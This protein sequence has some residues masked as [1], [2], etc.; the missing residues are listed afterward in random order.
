MDHQLQRILAQLDQTNVNRR[1]ILK[2]ALAAGAI[3]LSTFLAACGDD[4]DADAGDGGQAAEGGDATNTP[5]DSGDS[6]AGGET[7]AVKFEGWDYEPP[8]V[9]ENISRFMDLNPD[10]NVDY[11]PINGAEYRQKIVAEFTA[12]VEPDALYVR[13]DY[14]AGWVT[15]GYLQPIEG[16]PGLDEV[17]DRLFE[18]NANA[19]MY[20]G[21]RYGLPYYTDCDTF[22]FN[23]QMLDDAGIDE[24]PKT[25]DEIIEKGKQLK[26]AG[27][28]EYPL[29]L[30]F[31][32]SNNFWEAWWALIYASGAHL[33]DDEL[34]PI[35]H[36]DNTVA[37]DVLAW[38]KRGL[39]EGVIDPAIT[40]L[41][42]DQARDAFMAGQGAFH[43]ISRYDVERMNSPDQSNVAG[44]VK[45][46][47]IPS[48]D[49]ESKGTVGWH[50][51]YCISANT[52]NKE[53]AYKLIYYLGGLD[54]EDVPYTAKFWFMKRGLGFAFKDL[55]DD[56][57]IRAKL[58]EF[59]DPDVYFEQAT[60]ARPREAINESWYSEWESANQQTLQDVFIGRV[61]P[62]DAMQQMADNA[63]LFKERFG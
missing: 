26:E 9:E 59:I 48:L 11:I 4:D 50:R 38:I 55:D 43:I 14:F 20:N 21:E 12:G 32:L 5:S 41:D 3:S 46:S 49:G 61:D 15:A 57:E 56:P 22:V 33:F 35:M 2:T 42:S 31:K 17:Y 58:E 29:I 54:E 1:K 30:G 36:T 7:T 62:D 8:L 27:V 51:Q 13:D 40:E 18:Y 63:E 23:R 45:A 19:M 52:E 37:R 6:R 53:A 44:N 25:L 34:N 28:V 10:I 47:L 60:L 24:P 16:M 39:D